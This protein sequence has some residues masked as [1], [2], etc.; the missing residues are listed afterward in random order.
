MFDSEN[1]IFH[2]GTIF[3][4]VI[5]IIVIG[6]FLLKLFKSITQW[7]KNLSVEAKLKTKRTGR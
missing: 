1:T 7:Q 6:S 3:M 2:V 4:P 5:F